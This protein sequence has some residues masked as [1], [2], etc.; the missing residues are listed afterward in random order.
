MT[1]GPNRRGEYTARINRVLDYIQAHLAEEL[2]LEQ[3]ARVANFSRY[4]FHRVF[5]TLVGEPLGAHIQRLRVEKAARLLCFDP[6]VPVTNIA[7]DCGYSSSAAF[8]RAFR[9]AL[10]MSPSEWR[11]RAGSKIGIM[12]RNLGQVRRNPWKE[13]QIEWLDAQAIHNPPTWRMVMTIE[14]TNQATRQLEAKVEVNQ[15][16]EMHVAYLR[17][18]GPY[19]GDAALFGRLCGQLMRW[20]GPRGLM[21]PEAQM[22]SIYYDDPSL[23]DGSKLRLDVALTVPPDTEVTGEVCKM[24]LPAGKCAMARFEIAPEDYGLAWEAVSAWLPDSGYVPDDRPCYEIYRNDP[25][26]HP[27]GKHVVDIC[28]PVK[29]ME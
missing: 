21:S 3:L 13:I 24:T 23:T 29:P 20:A 11:D 19:A 25:Q 17:H 22:L 7:L 18:I 5:R 12:D 16:P 10:G 2:T 1:S 14:T 15:L 9:E 8:S 27:E 28:I 26:Q 6:S 4:H